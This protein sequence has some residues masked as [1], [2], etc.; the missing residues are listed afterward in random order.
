MKEI[1]TVLEKKLAESTTKDP[2][3]K[4]REMQE[5]FRIIKNF[6]T[7]YRM[8]RSS[9]ERFNFEVITETLSKHSMNML[10]SSLVR[11][12]YFKN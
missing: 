4:I 8:L 12:T 10:D 9:D 3:S 1:S 5:E 11:T 7:H 2:E 6:T